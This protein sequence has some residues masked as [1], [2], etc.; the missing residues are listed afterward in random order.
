MGI[1]FDKKIT[2]G[3]LI[4][5]V[6]AIG[7]L[8]F[9]FATSKAHIEQHEIKIRSLQEIS[10]SLELNEQRL[11]AIVEMQNTRIERL[12]NHLLDGS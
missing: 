7:A 8:I 4:A 1:T 11:T 6:S 9:A 10:H 2:W 12:E 5:T 3:N